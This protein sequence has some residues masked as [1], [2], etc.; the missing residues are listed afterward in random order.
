MSSQYLSTGRRRP[1][2]TVEYHLRTEPV[3]YS[4][5]GYEAV[6]SSE[7]SSSSSGSNLSASQM[8]YESQTAK[9]FFQGNFEFILNDQSDHSDHNSVVLNAVYTDDEQDEATG[10]EISR[11]EPVVRDHSCV[12]MENP[13]FAEAAAVDTSTRTMN[14]GTT[15][16]VRGC[17]VVGNPQASLDDMDRVH[18]SLRENLPV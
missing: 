3:T 2:I 4:N 17:V 10:I 13:S 16:G 1:P 14:D 8:S 5:D 18:S 15:A 6:P 12:V 9:A 7:V 11:S